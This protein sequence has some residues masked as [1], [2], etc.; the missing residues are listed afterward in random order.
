MGAKSWTFRIAATCPR[1]RIMQATV[2]SANPMEVYSPT[3]H[4]RKALA[5]EDQAWPSI[6]MRGEAISLA[7]A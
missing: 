4:S 1:A 2:M 3:S 7:E 5:D 6:T